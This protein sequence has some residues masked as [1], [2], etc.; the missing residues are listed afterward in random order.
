MQHAMNDERAEVIAFI[1]TDGCGKSTVAEKVAGWIAARG[2]T[3]TLHKVSSGRSQLD[4]FARTEGCKDLVSLVGGDVALMMQVGIFWKSM[5]DARPLV[6]TPR[7]F[8]LFD[9]YTW[10]YLALARMHAPERD[11]LVRGLFVK[12]RAPAITFFMDVPPGIAHARLQARGSSPD[13]IEFL[14]AFDAAYRALP[15]FE[16]FVLIDGTRT[17]DETIAAVCAELSRRYVVLA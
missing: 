12:F 15:E 6:R 17:P 2:Q 1:G 13:S 5:R 9:R 4:K 7:S 16:S 3:A 10:C 11:A 8:A 14:T